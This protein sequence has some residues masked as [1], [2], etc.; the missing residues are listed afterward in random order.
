MPWQ[1][2]P[3]SNRH[4]E[5]QQGVAISTKFESSLRAP[6]GCGNLNRIRIVIANP[7]GMWQSQPIIIL[8]SKPTF[9]NKYL[10]VAAVYSM[11]IV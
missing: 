7:N 1:S 10:H 9:V 4:C 11:M 6:T 3:N 5:S 8:P 2:Q